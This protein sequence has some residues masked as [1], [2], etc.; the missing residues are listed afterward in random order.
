[1]AASDEASVRGQALAQP[2]DTRERVDDDEAFAFRPGNE[3]AAI[4]GA[5]VEQ[6]PDCRAGPEPCGTGSAILRLLLHRGRRSIP[7][8]RSGV[9]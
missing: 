6:R 8:A 7:G 5:E 2:H 4:V 9:A 3:Q 1:M